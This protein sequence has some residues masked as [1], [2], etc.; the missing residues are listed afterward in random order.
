MAILGGIQSPPGFLERGVAVYR[1]LVRLRVDLLGLWC[2]ILKTW[3][4]VSLYI[5]AENGKWEGLT[6]DMADY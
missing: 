2:G 6:S 3:L 1:R 5:R 4:Q